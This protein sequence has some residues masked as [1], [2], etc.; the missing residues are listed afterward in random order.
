[1][2]SCFFL[3]QSYRWLERF[4]DAIRHLELADRL[5]P[6][7]PHILHALGCARQLNGDL[8]RAKLNFAQA[9]DVD[10]DSVLTYNSLAITQRML[11]EYE[12]AVYNYDAG[13]KALARRIMMRMSDSPANPLV[14]PRETASYLWAGYASYAAIWSAAKANL[15]G[16]AVPS[17]EL[18]QAESAHHANGGRHYVDCDSP[19]GIVRQLLPNFFEAF[20]EALIMEE[21]YPLLLE[22]R[23]RAFA[24]LGD[25]EQSHMHFSEAEE[26]RALRGSL[27]IN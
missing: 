18:A 7:S 20:R 8:E 19:K 21:L 14:P 26:F 1:M 2:A 6:H 27:P 13:L 24:E 25:T 11:G 9:L 10:S 22:N 12:K 5:N 17:S 4:P 23:G 16:V 3:G 15:A